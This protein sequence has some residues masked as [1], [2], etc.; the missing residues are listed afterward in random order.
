MNSPSYIISLAAH[1]SCSTDTCILQVTALTGWTGNPPGAEWGTHIP[2]AALQFQAWVTVGSWEGTRGTCPL[3]SSPPPVFSFFLQPDW[4]QS[5]TEFWSGLGW[6][7][8]TC[9]QRL[10]PKGDPEW[11]SLH[12]SQT[13]HPSRPT[14]EPIASR[15]LSRIVATF[16]LTPSWLWTVLI[17]SVQTGTSQVVQWLRICLPLQRMR[18]QSMVRELRSHMP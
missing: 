4:L 13:P 1:S 18:V 5:P 10:W 6:A 9:T 12:K 16:P 7:G 8:W 14:S 11:P 2:R 15:K 3:N 17:K